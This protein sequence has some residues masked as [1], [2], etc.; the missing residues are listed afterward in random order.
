MITRCIFVLKAHYKNTM[1]YSPNIIII[2]NAKC[3]CLL[4]EL[5]TRDHPL[6]LVD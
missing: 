5:M 6:E 2:I 1:V 3:L 4:V